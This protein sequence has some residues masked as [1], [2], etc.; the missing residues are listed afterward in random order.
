MEK[1]LL[2]AQSRDVVG[3]KVKGYR[4]DGMVPAVVYGHQVEPKNLWVSF[5]DFS[6][7]YAKAGENTIVELQV[8]GGKGVNVLIHDTQLDPLSGNFSHVD[9]FQVRMDEEIE[10]AIPLEFVGESEAVK[11]LGGMLLKNIDE[12]E[13]SCL[14]ADLPHSIA[15]DISVL[16]TFDDHIKVVDLQVPAKVKVVSEPETIV[17]SVEAP[18]TEAELAALDEKVD[19]DVTKVE[20]VVKEAPAAEEK[21]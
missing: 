20:G 5:L 7:M 9:F 1:L 14:P 13:V 10:A 11:T 16:K 15:V 2:Q 8:D 12:V 6:R 4:K 21:K 17:A 3:K 18:R 19:A